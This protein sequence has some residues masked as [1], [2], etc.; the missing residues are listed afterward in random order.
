MEIFGLEPFVIAIA[1]TAVGV[2]LSVLLGWLKGNEAFN[3]KQV[4]ASA[5]I[6]FVISIQLVIAE[7]TVLPSDLDGLVLGSIIFALIAQVS[8]ID[9]LTKSA[10]Q[11][12]SKARKLE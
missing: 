7:L 12:V 11:A 4:V 1:I 3:V 5:L 9:S 10:A 8:G 6:A 2:A